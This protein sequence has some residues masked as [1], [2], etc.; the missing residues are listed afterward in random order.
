MRA[1]FWGTVAVAA[2]LT[3][4]SAPSDQPETK[5]PQW[6]RGSN[7]NVTPVVGPPVPNVPAVP[8]DT[9][10]DGIPYGAAGGASA[11]P[12]DQTTEAQP[13]GQEKAAAAGPPATPQ[14]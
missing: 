6:G 12:T 9:V 10:A 5:A 11:G 13:A 1:G 14:T 3:G 8:I 7:A 2:F 4:C